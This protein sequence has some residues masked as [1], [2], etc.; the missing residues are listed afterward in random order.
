[1]K[2]YICNGADSDKCFDCCHSFEHEKENDEEDHCSQ[3]SDCADE[4]GNIMKKVRCVSIES[5][6]GRRVVKNIQEK[7]N[8]VYK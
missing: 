7:F 6:T 4:D 3:W 2:L 8:L 5:K 1:M